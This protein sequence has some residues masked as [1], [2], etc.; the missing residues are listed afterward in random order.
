MAYYIK[1]IWGPDGDCYATDGFVGFPINCKNVS[2]KFKEC[3][4][5]VIYETG[6]EENGRRGNMS[7]FAIGE[8]SCDQSNLPE[9]KL[10]WGWYV[11]VNIIKRV[12]PRD[13]VPIEKL[14]SLGIAQFQIPGG[15]IP[16]TKEQFEAIATE[17]NSK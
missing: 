8:I 4:G 17:F 1:T 13:G 2:Q 5:F 3:D 7:V 10:K 12:D 16:I 15:L 14:R 6:R 9:N 11:R